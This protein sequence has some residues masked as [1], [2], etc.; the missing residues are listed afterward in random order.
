MPVQPYP[1]LGIPDLKWVNRYLAIEEV[2]RKLNLRFGEHGKLH[3]WHPERHQHGDRTPSV[4]VWRRQNKVKCFGCQTRLIGPVDLVMDVLQIGLP[5]AT[6]WIAAN[7]QVP[8]IP[9]GKHLREP[10]RHIF[11]VGCESPMELLVR[12][13]LWARLAPPTQRLV[14]VLLGL[15][16]PGAGDRLTLR[17]SYRALMRY[18]GIRSFNSVSSSLEE[19]RELGWLQAVPQARSN[20]LVRDAATYVLTPSSDA[21]VELANA[22]AAETRLEIEL[23]RELRK[24]E[25]N[26]RIRA[27]ASS[28]NSSP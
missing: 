17:I 21:I 5:D 9:K 19:L 24:A 23:E 22:T 4:G 25:K 2:S 10:H 28:S 11:P 7:F 26:G 8:Q 13:G 15:A 27:R 3:C 16:E 18:S 6:S 14:P 12:S 1:E 20:P